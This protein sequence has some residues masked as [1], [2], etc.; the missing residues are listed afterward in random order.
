M[1]CADHEILCNFLNMGVNKNGYMITA[2]NH[3]WVPFDDDVSGYYKENILNRKGLF[4]RSQVENFRKHPEQYLVSA[5]DVLRTRIFVQVFG[6][7]LWPT[8]FSNLPFIPFYR[9]KNM[10][11]IDTVYKNIDR[12]KVGKF[13]QELMKVDQELARLS[14]EDFVGFMPRVDKDYEM[15]HNLRELAP[16]NMRLM[17]IYEVV[18][19]V[20]Y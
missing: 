11:L 18:R 15:V 6:R 3:P 4:G 8:N 20:C 10:N 16:K 1:H 14:I 13:R 7:Y 2:L 5:S 17:P 12:K 9:S 19:S